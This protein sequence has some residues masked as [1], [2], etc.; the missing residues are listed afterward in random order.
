MLPRCP[1]EAIRPMFVPQFQ[2]GLCETAN[3][4]GTRGVGYSNGLSYVVEHVLN[5]NIQILPCH[6][7]AIGVVQSLHELCSDLLA[8]TATEYLARRL[9]QGQE[10]SL[11]SL[12]RAFYVLFA[13]LSEGSIHE[14]DHDQLSSYCIKGRSQYESVLLPSIAPLW[15]FLLVLPIPR[16]HSLSCLLHVLLRSWSWGSYNCISKINVNLSLEGWLPLL[17]SL[18]VDLSYLADRRGDWRMRLRLS[19]DELALAPAWRLVESEKLSHSFGYTLFCCIQVHDFNIIFL[20]LHGDVSASSSTRSEAPV[21]VSI[22]SHAQSACLP[23]SHTVAFLCP[24]CTVAPLLC[25]L[26]LKNIEG[27]P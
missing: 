27:F 23:L 16:L 6:V 17:M 19:G 26:L 22:A 14:G 5:T 13:N 21:S 7:E 3:R 20:H 2:P 8:C 9:G 11:A 10:C 1:E 18:S 15:A 24:V 4:S 25:I 12:G